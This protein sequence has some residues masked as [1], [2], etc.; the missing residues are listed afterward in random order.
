MSFGTFIAG[1]QYPQF[2]DSHGHLGFLYGP[3][4]VM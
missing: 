4:T 2:T 3:C 1:F